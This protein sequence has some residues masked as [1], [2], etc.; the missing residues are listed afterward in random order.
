MTKPELAKPHLIDTHCHIDF[1]DYDH[2]RANV[3][4]NATESGVKDII[5]PSVA[6]SSWQKTISTC[7][8]FQQCHL[9][10]GLHPVFIE[11]HQPQHLN[12]LQTLVKKHQP[13]A[14]GEIGLDYYIRSLDQEKQRAFFSKQL[15]LAQQVQ[16]PAII[17]NRKA[18][19]DAIS[20]INELNFH[21]GIIHAF[22]GSIQQAQKYIEKGFLLGF[23][24][25]LTFARSSK[26]TRLAE[27]IPLQSIVL[28]TDSPDMTVAQ[29]KGERNSPEY[30]PFI[31]QAVAKVKK[32]STAEV[33]ATTTLNAQRLFKLS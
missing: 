32:L 29:H 10:L 17:H 9:A 1:D 24:G 14:I 3:I 30:I 27:A 16:L 28:E 6:Q 33:A 18:H 11:Q 31:L 26:L 8:Q 21:G 4:A 7:A 19:D 12:E 25:M 22:N 20:I 5:V 13:I 2:D 23:G 15:I